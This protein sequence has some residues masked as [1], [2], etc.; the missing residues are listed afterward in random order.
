MRLGIITDIHSNIIALNAVLN[1]FKKRKVDKIIC[2]GDI[3]GIGPSPEETVQKIIDIKEKLIVVQGNHEQY[4]LKGLPKNVHDD[5]RKMSQDEI[6]NHEWIHS[7][8]SDSSKKFISEIPLSQNIEVE[9]KKIY[10]VHYPLDEKENYKKFIKEPSIEECEELFNEK[11]DI[12]LFGHTHSVS[13]NT[14][15][16]KWYINP[17]SLGCPLKSNVAKAGILDIDENK[18][19]F[20]QLNITYNVDE[21]IEEINKLKFPFYEGILR[22]F[23]GKV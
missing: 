22:I 23:Y 15:E 14:K 20:E 21:V 7:M 12:Y 13:I 16:N 4:L 18:V 10:I 1:E 8:L 2:C 9:N 17:G 11:A 5:K 3:I 6:R 19:N